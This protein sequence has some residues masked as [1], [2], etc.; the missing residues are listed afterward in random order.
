MTNF[1]DGGAAFFVTRVASGD[2]IALGALAAA[3]CAAAPAGA[4][5][6][7][8]ADA[9]AE[10]AQLGDIVV[11]ANR[12]IESVNKVSAS[13]AAYDQVKLD[14]QGVRNFSDIV[15]QTPGLSLQQQSTFQPAN[16]AIRGVRSTVGSAT[17]G[18]YIDDTPIQTR[19]AGA[20]SPGD[21]LPAIFDIQR[22]EVLRG[23]QG[24]L[25]GSGSEGGAVR[26]ISPTPDLDAISAYGR[27]EVLSTDGGGIGYEGGIAAGTPIVEGKLAVRLSASY[28]HDA[29]FVDRINERT[30]AVV[31]KNANSTNTHT[32]K[33]AL[34]WAPTDGLRVSP[35]LNFQET[36][37][38]DSSQFYVRLSDRSD[39]KLISG[40]TNRQPS[41]D[42]FYLPALK[43][44]ADIGAMTATSVT[45]LFTRRQSMVLDFTLLDESVARL[46]NGLRPPATQ[47]P[48]I[49]TLPVP[50]L[51]PEAFAAAG[52]ATNTTDNKQRNFTQELR[53]QS[54]DTSSTFSWLVGGFY[55][56]AKQQNLINVRDAYYADTFEI[57]RGIPNREEIVRYYRN[58]NSTDE[59]L[60]AF[61]NIDFR[62]GTLTL[63][64][65]GRIASTKFSF[66]EV[67]EGSFVPP[68][69]RAV[70]AGKQKESPFTPKVSLTWEPKDSTL[71]YASASKGFRVGGANIPITPSPPCLASLAT[72]GLNTAPGT[73]DSDSVWNYEL[74][75]KFG[76]FDR[77]VQVNAS[78]YHIDW[79]NIQSFVSLSGCPGGF[80][81][82][83]GSANSDG[84]DL[85]ISARPTDALYLSLAA[86]YNKSRFAETISS[87][88]II[89]AERGAEVSDAPPWQITT[90]V[91]Y[92]LPIGSGSGYVRGI[93]QYSSRNKGVIS[94]YDTPT[95]SGYDANGR[96]NDG[97][98]LTSLRIG[99]RSEDFDISLFA[100]NLLNAH[101][102]LNY[103]SNAFP[104]D[105]TYYANTL[106][107]RTI[108][109]TLTARH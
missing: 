36:R 88:G 24:T 67:L 41:K 94:R 49:G 43:V 68:T 33:G 55:Q 19:S 29:G 71:L 91:E 92:Q 8:P 60:A 18:I 6:T 93:N 30:G 2:F 103:V 4:Q 34:L 66:D 52:G 104:T 16:I 40:R 81:T 102:E 70:A 59:Q 56:R 62:L 75:G 20:Q 106:R 45:S 79:S 97:Y 78:A 39:Q 46:F 82:N 76:L 31:D 65:G 27:G 90:T 53:L 32:M 44:E 61:G 100:D 50:I 89:L 5:G 84:F 107:P 57:L 105:T 109:L 101:P 21:A 73:Y 25:F 54:N 23:P 80:I 10:E 72:L 99:W 108:G 86:G 98:H 85:S 51:I 42:R 96:R 63:S 83:L 11:T 12:R 69:G 14:Q 37:G 3:I 47:L 7:P 48:G 74:G 9:A 38:R 64:A 77:K 28:R 87:N 26:F 13:I 95:S 15:S 17:T 1:T 58:F 22:V 35:S